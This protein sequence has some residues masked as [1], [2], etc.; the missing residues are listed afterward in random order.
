MKMGKIGPV[1]TAIIEAVAGILLILFPS[2]SAQTLSYVAGG[3]FAVWGLITLVLFFLRQSGKPD[4]FAQG[5]FQIA[6]GLF[7]VFRPE[8]IG[9]I[10]PYMLA[11][12]ML[13][14][15]C[16]QLQ[17]AVRMHQAESSQAMIAAILGAAET[18]LAL[19]LIAQAFGAGKAAYIVQGVGFVAVAV[20]DMVT[21]FALRRGEK[22]QA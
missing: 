1:F 4:G 10:V 5:L 8:L 3:V 9:A 21:R 17:A 15:C 13:M 14:G 2:T 18:V 12:V 6:L 20:I 22:K 16:Q 11:F 19:L 7:M